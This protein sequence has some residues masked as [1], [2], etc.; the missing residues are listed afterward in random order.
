M[1]SEY[2]DQLDDRLALGANLLGLSFGRARA[3]FVRTRQMPDGGFAGR[4]GKSDIYYTDFALRTL[5]MLEPDGQ[6]LRNAAA[7]AGGIGGRPATV[8]ECFNRLNCARMLARPGID[9]D[10]DA[11]P[12]LD[13]LEE[14]GPTAYD[15]FLAALCHD[16]LGTTFPNLKQATRT[17]S[18]GLVRARDDVQTSDTAAAVG[19]LMM[20][21]ALDDSTA[22]IAADGIA[23]MQASAGGFRAHREAP[24]PDLLSTFTALVTLSALRALGRADLAAAGRFVRSLADGGGFRACASDEETD[25]EYTY[26]GVATAALLR[27]YVAAP[28]LRGGGTKSGH[29]APRAGTP[30][31]PN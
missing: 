17:I 10:L 9:V 8:A 18:D 2:L 29:T 11:A 20:S 4:R 28:P 26:Y 12:L 3:D 22:E 25:V 13:R 7:Y 6:T 5:G 21:N 24:E 30:P 15:A 14:T 31:S 1:R 19:F 27:E 23:P 16:M